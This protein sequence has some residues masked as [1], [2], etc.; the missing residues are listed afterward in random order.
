MQNLTM[1]SSTLRNTG[2]YLIGDP[3]LEG[4]ISLSHHALVPGTELDDAN[5]ASQPTD[6][7]MTEPTTQAVQSES[8]PVQKSTDERRYVIG[9][10]G[11]GTKTAC[12]VMDDKEY[13]WAQIRGGSTNRNS[14]GDEEAFANLQGVIQNALRL[15]GREA[16]EISAICLGMAGADRQQDR[17]IIQGWVESL[18]PHATITIYNDALIALASGTKAELC[19]IAVISG[20]GMLVYGINQQQQTQRAGG[21]GPLFGDRGSGY[22]IGLAGLT[23]VAQATD[24]LGEPTALDGAFRDYLD[25]STPQALIP[26]AYAD[27]SWA[28][29]ADLATIVVECAL[30]DDAVAKRIV[31]EQ[32][33][34]LA[35]AVEL[36]VRGL[37]MLHEATPIVLSGG[38]LQP[39]MFSNLVQQHLSNLLPNAQ[40]LRPSVEPAVGAAQLALKSES[41]SES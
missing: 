21:W 12:V 3:S 39:G 38:T 23:A 19:G 10:D 37:D 8:Q 33:I 22:A 18:L 4:S 6:T 9:I 1:H 14:T 20:T 25:L 24:G 31:A 36:V 16:T 28:R 5:S 29:I 2:A 13:I 15:A 17:L 41:Q 26:W 27:R 30:Q 7:A 40:L 34:D 32:A 11:G 35:A